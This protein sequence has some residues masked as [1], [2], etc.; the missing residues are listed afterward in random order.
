MKREMIDISPTM[1]G[2]NLILKLGVNILNRNL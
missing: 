2:K 1:F